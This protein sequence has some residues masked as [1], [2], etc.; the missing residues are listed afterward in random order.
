M[1]LLLSVS[2]YFAEHAIYVSI[3]SKP[4]HLRR[5]NPREFFERANSSPPGHKESAKPRPL[6]QKNSAKTPPL[7]NY[8]QKSSKNTTKHETEIT[9]KQY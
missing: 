8:F 6:G 9:K 1:G 5:A 3:N 4:D 7:G 2:K